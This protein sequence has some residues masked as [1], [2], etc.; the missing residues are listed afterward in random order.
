[1]PAALTWYYTVSNIITVLLQVVIQRFVIN[2]DK[3]L[4]QIQQ[5]RKQ[6]KKKSAWMLKAE[7]L[8]RERMNRRK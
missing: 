4:L 3:L 2:H 1:M 8:Q 5:K 7:Q 6:P